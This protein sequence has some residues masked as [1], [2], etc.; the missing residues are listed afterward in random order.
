MRH[1]F[2]LLIVAMLVVGCAKKDVEKARERMQKEGSAPETAGKPPE[3]PH[4]GM[5]DPHAGIPGM[6]GMGDAGDV[7]TDGKPIPLKLT[8]NGGAAEL[9]REL[10]KI[11]DADVAQKFERAFRL[12]FSTD[13]AQRDYDAARELLRG[14]VLAQPRF[15]PAHRALGYAEFN[16]GR[17]DLA[18]QEYRKAVDLEPS[19][20]EAHYAM[21][22]M[23]ATQDLEEGYQH[24]R[25]A[26]EL[27]V[28]DERGI[29][30]S[31]YKDFQKVH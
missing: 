6:G 20:G 18:I 2:L 29:G 25:K 16:L 3:N 24:Y 11:E 27:G 17:I 4:G 15:A 19:Y 7:A 13:R 8:G 31:I 10:A 26:M 9:A 14:I 5:S 21:A 28:A 12:T 22:F 23:L 30:E 1:G